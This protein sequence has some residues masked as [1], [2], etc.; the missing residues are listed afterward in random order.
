M[1]ASGGGTIL[2]IRESISTRQAS[3]V[4]VV[5]DVLARIDRHNAAL[6]A[7]LEVFGDEA[8]ARASA[9]DEQLRD[10]SFVP[11]PLTGVPVV[12]KDNIC[13]DRGRTTCASRMLAEYRSPFSATSVLRLEAAGAVIIG[14]ANMDEFAMGSSG[15][16]S[17]FGPTRNP[18]DPSRVPGGSSSGSA[19]SVAAR[20]APCAL[21]S[22]TGGSIRQ[23]ASYTGTVGLKPTYGRVSR[24][25]LVA[26]ASSL[27]QIGPIT[28]SVTD[29]A[30]M[31]D[32]IA[33]YD[34]LDSTSVRLD[35]PRAFEQVD[36]PVEGLRLGVAREA[37]SEA[38]DPSVRAAFDGAMQVFRDMGAEVIDIDLPMLDA[39]ISTYYLVATA[40]AS[41]NLARYDGIRY[42]RRAALAEGEGLEA[43]Y[44]RSRSEGFG[45]EVQR[46]IMLGCHALS[47][48]YYDAYYLTALKARRLIK[49]DFD[50]AF[51]PEDGSPGVHAV[52]MPT[53]PSAAFRLGEKS[54]DPMSM[55]LED[56]YTVGANL[57]GLPAISVPMGSGAND[58]GAHLPLGLQIIAPAFE[59]ALL[60]R[61]ARMYE[62]SAPA[63]PGPAGFA[64]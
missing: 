61:I 23:P 4:S 6:N 39:G 7:M 46:R 62:R 52:V 51:R 28:R 41:S 40:E 9:L 37:R 43:L 11:G 53:A 1:M 17:F 22:D 14:K 49:R 13:T 26:F 5:D 8:R 19:A 20:F 33:G 12:V 21:G 42:G 3:C 35:P 45:P 57:A 64:D 54:A 50:R 63:M 38:N 55:Y 44:A 36:R 32:V 34:E 48:G 31:L 60:L 16:R 25:G 30:L 59:D 27:D 2:E 15:E 47:S 29:S 18:H 56:I 58:S 24:W 10:P